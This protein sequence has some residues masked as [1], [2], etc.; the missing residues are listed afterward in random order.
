[1][2]PSVTISLAIIT[3]KLNENCPLPIIF[4]NLH[5]NIIII[6]LHLNPLPKLEMG[7]VNVPCLN[8]L[9]EPQVIA[10][11]NHENPVSGIC[12][13]HCQFGNLSGEFHRYLLKHIQR[14]GGLGTKWLK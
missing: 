3:C 2:T 1:M 5:N 13:R 4:E 11:C 7:V 10:E 14:E 8:K 12:T 6:C 9:S